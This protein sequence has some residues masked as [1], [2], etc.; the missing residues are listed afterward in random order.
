MTY[1]I[2]AAIVIGICY[3]GWKL[4]SRN[5][6]ESAEYT[7]LELEPLRRLVLESEM[8]FD[9]KPRLIFEV[10][11]QGHLGTLSSSNGLRLTIGAF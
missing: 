7:V 5:A 1:I 6:Y 4:T 11:A 3:V 9:P 10:T 2:V 8:P